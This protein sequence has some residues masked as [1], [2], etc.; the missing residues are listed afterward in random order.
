MKNCKKSEVFN[1][2]TRNCDKKTK[3]V[4]PTPNNTDS[5]CPVSKPVWNK[6]NK[7]CEPCP[8][9]LP[10]FSQKSLSCIK[11][12]KSTAWSES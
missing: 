7:I 12:P 6:V 2:A 3:P 11:C 8:Q 9:S 10:Y 5:V 1:K 4:A